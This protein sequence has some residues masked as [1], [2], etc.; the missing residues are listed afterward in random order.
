VFDDVTS[1]ALHSALNGLSTRQ[2]IIAN[3]IS[4]LDTPGFRAGRIDFESQ[5][6]SALSSGS[7]PAVT[8]TVSQSLDATGLNGNNVNLDTETL[9]NV[10]T[11]LRYQ[12]AIRATD[13]QFGL[14]RS[15]LRSA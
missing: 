8:G 6:Q 11:G 12:L 14:L 13:D 7:S 1:L 9:S 5:L 15:A 2:Q 3:N 4:N 10:E